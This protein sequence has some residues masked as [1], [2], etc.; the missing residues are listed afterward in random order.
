MNFK[1]AR[2][3]VCVDYLQFREVSKFKWAAVCINAAR[4]TDLGVVILLLSTIDY[5]R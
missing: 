3:F 4:H 5:H 2:D 1:A